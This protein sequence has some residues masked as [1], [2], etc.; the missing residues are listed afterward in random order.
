MGIFSDY[1]ID[2][3]SVKE[4]SFDVPDGTYRFEIAEGE[5]LDGTQNKPDTTF[6]VIDYQLEDEHSDAA[7]SYREWYVLAENGDSE[8][9]R[10]RQSVGF[11][12]SRLLKLGLKGS[13]LADFDGSEIIGITGTMRLKTKPGRK[14]GTEFQNIATMKVDGVDGT[15]VEE[16]KEPEEAPAKPARKAPAKRA[17]KPAAAKEPEADEDENPF[18]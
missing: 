16:E 6:F 4:N 1:D 18:S 3:D 15:D 17:A 2:I 9:K 7:G 5:E 12:K 13:Q 14:Q 11:L 10:A 8:T